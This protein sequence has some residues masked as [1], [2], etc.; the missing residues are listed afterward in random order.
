MLLS[1]VLEMTLPGLI[2]ALLDPGAYP[3]RPREVFLRQTHASYLLFTPDFVYKIKK[4]VDF[5]FLDFTT[6]EKRLH[7]CE[8]EVRLN[9]RLAPDVYLGV[10]KITRK[11]GGYAAGGSGE[12]VEYAVRMKRLPSASILEEMLKRDAVTRGM[13]KDVARR[14][15]SFHREAQTDE[16]ISG[17]GSVDIIKKNTNENFA[18]TAGFVGSAVSERLFTKIRDYTGDFIRANGALFGN[19]MNEG[20]I[21][22][23]HGDLHCEHVSITDGIDIFDC[24]EFNE[25]FRFSDV[26]ADI[27][28]LSMD[29]D[30]HNRNDLTRV[31]DSEY[32]SATRDTDGRKLMD[33]YKCYRAYVRG[34]VEGFKYLQEEVISTEKYLAFI[35]ACHHFYLAGLY[36]DERE[37]G[38][39]RFRPL[40]IAVRGLT[41]TG[42]TAV[43]KALAE[44]LCMVHLSSDAVRKELAGVS[45]KE[46][47]F[48]GFKEGIYADE[49]TAKTYR[50]LIEKG[51]WFL[52]SGRSV[53][54]DA[55]FSNVKYLYEVK[56]SVEALGRDAELYVV[57][58]G[59]KDEA[60]KGRL[61]KRAAGE[62]KE[63]IAVSDADWEIYLRQKESFEPMPADI[64]PHLRLSTE[65]PL[66]ETVKTIV[67][68]VFS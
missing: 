57:E 43:A 52:K 47:R 31:L 48:A 7:F 49:F 46:H 63:G 64:R 28:F 15:A 27:A 21:R 42:K 32:F 3:D 55:T 50:A 18:Q 9:R 2:E 6:L 1:G 22:D 19:R 41:G 68:N 36:A 10:E 14:V 16:H 30:F 59:A 5:G 67:T 23:C 11:D 61:L 53:V 8:E 20:F 66:E 24:I 54:L 56:S 40:M 25:R 65:G 37:A 38:V 4:P 29:L 60:V 45:P 44:G 17:F 33:F 51:V 26:V 12:A 39:G 13:I 34:K 58:C 35:N 62:G